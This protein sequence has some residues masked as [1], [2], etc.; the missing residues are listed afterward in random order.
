MIFVFFGTNVQDGYTFFSVQGNTSGKSVPAT[1]VLFLLFFY[2]AVA[3]Y[4]AFMAY[5]YILYSILKREFKILQFE[6]SAGP[7]DEEGG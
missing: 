2:Y 4:I 6:M 3:A 1:V 5:K 7:V